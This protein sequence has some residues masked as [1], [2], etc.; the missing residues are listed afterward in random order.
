MRIVEGCNSYG[1]CCD[2]EKVGD[3]NNKMSRVFHAAGIRT[4][5]TDVILF[6][7]ARK[8]GA[9]KQ[10]GFEE[11]HSLLYLAELLCH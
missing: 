9:R 8:G 10:R 4:P 11:I 2:A 6:A 1:I 3:Q 7:F 5:R